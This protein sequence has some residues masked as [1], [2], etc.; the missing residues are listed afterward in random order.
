M[1]KI[2][3]FVLFCA[4]VLKP[5][6][7]R[8]QGFIKTQLLPVDVADLSL[9]N[10]A[11]NSQKVI[12]NNLLG[13]SNDMFSTSDFNK[14]ISQEKE[15]VKTNSNTR[16]K[17][18]IYPVKA[19]TT[20][21]NLPT[22]FFRSAVDGGEWNIAGNWQFSPDNGI[23]PWEIA[24][25][26][27]GTNAAAIIIHNGYNI[28]SSGSITADD[29]IIE[30]G[31]AL[32]ING[33]SFTINNGVAIADLQVDGNVTW[34]DGVFITTG[35]GVSFEA[36]ATYTHAINFSGEIPAAIWDAAATCIVTGMTTSSTAPTGLNQLFG[37]F[38]WNCD[39]T[40]SADN[41]LINNNLFGVAGT[42][43]INHTGAAY[44]AIVGAT[45][46]S[47]TNTVNNIEVNSGTLLLNDFNTGGGYS[48]L[49][50]TGDITVADVTTA[51]LDFVGGAGNPAGTD[52][53]ATLNLAGNLTVGA[54]AYFSRSNTAVNTNSILFFNGTVGTQMVN[55]GY[56]L[57][58]SRGRIIYSVQ[59]DA[60]VQL[61][62]YLWMWDA[63]TMYVYGTI[64]TL[65]YSIANTGG[66]VN[67]AFYNFPG[68]TLITSL[69]NGFTAAAGSG[70]VQT[71]TR[72]YSSAADYEFRGSNTGN[73]TTITT[74]L[75]GTVRNLTINYYGVNMTGNITVTG[76]LKL[77][78][79]GQFTLPAFNTLTLAGTLPAPAGTIDAFS[80]GPST[81]VLANAG[82]TIN[83]LL[84]SPT[85]NLY[86]LNNNPPSGI[87]TLQG[88]FIIARTLT[89][90]GGILDNGNN[91][92]TLGT[93]GNEEPLVKI[94]G[95]LHMDLGSSLT[96]GRV[97]SDATIPDGVFTSGPRFASLKLSRGDGRTVTLGNQGMELFTGLD[98]KRGTLNIGNS[99]LNLNGAY[100]DNSGTPGG[101]LAG[102]STSDLTVTGYTGGK[103]TIPLPDFTDINLRTVT[104]GGART[105]AMASSPVNNINLYGTLSIETQGI[106]DN[107]GESQ[108]INAGGSAAIFIDGTFITRDLQGFTGANAAVSGIDPVLNPECT[109]EYGYTGDQDISIRN[110][111]QN[112]R[113]TGGGIKKP[114]T[115]NDIAPIA[116]T[117]I[118]PDVT[119]VNTEGNIFGSAATN[120]TMFNGRFITAGSGIKPNMNGTYNLSGGV[121]EFAGSETTA[122]TIQT[123]KS[124]L[125][126][127]VT[128]NN[129]GKA[130]G[131]I[132]IKN[133]GTFTVKSNGIFTIIEDAITGPVGSQLVVVES[134]ATFKCGNADGFNGGN[135]TS[136]KSDVE[137]INLNAGSILEYARSSGS[138][139]QV[140]TS[141]ITYHHVIMSGFGVKNLATGTF[142][143]SSTGS[144]DIKAPVVFDAED[145]TAIDF[146]NR[147]VQTRST[148]AGTASLGDLTGVTVQNA[149]DAF[150]VERFMPDRRAWRLITTPL[151]KTGTT[152]IS[153]AWQ[154]GQQSTDRLNPVIG[155]NGI[156]T[157]IT[158]GLI[159]A[160]GYDAGS[161]ANA[162]LKYFNAGNW[163]TPSATTIPINTYPGYML[164]VRGDRQMIITN[165]FA[166]PTIT[167][168]I[169]KGRI[170]IG[171]QNPITAAGFQVVGNPYPS[172]I[173]FKKVIKSGGLEDKYY[174]WDPKLGGAFGAGAFVSFLRNGT[175]YDE[176]LVASDG[177]SIGPSGSTLP[178]DGT[179]ESGAA[180]MADFGA[181]GTGTLQ[182]D[183]SVKINTSASAPFGRPLTPVNSNQLSLRINMAAFNSDSSLFLV[184]GVL[185]TFNADYTNE[186]D[187]N[188]A[189]KIKSFAEN[190]GL[191][192]QEQSIAIE[193]RKLLTEN[194]TIFLQLSGLKVRKYRLELEA[195]NLAKQNLAGYLEDTYLTTSTAINMDGFTSND[196]MPQNISA[197]SVP[198]RFRIVFKKSVTYNTINA[199]RLNN[200]IAIDW[201]VTGERDI[202][203]Y[204]I[205]RSK[206]GANFTA[207]ITTLAKADNSDV[208]Y[209]NGVDEG[210]LF[211]G[212][213]YYRIKSTSN[214]GAIGYSNLAKV[215]VMNAGGNMYVY[216]NPVSNGS[217]GLQMNSM[218]AGIYHL[219]LFNSA[220]QMLFS[221]TINYGGGT[222][223]F[224]I[225]YPLQLKG[226]AELEITGV[227]KKKTVLK[228]IVE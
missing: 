79:G 140:V 66:A 167:T 2:Y 201:S 116:G 53:V 136:V 4:L 123:S 75:P 169:P 99:L 119:T 57:N 10:Y 95:T 225:N 16:S 51:R 35:A 130:S 184:D 24:T 63:D 186:V 8:G 22:D 61:K 217:M 23:T 108:L 41:F 193:R 88:D 15:I 139:N 200:A 101:Y 221:K 102:T 195:K 198:Y 94:N 105:L 9:T 46:A 60:V 191:L 59:A 224:S 25:L 72:V 212:I 100:L 122:Q 65:G 86:Y 76:A 219:R 73:F 135:N 182:F 58:T 33:G 19:A 226:N 117:V 38:T 197:G 177:S 131:D 34:R 28:I 228:V 29:I 49:N 77:L 215:T 188:D 183:E 81:I 143:L 70:A 181:T 83:N 138:G 133:S 89:L 111:Y 98:L 185:A 204:E 7:S 148:I 114:A 56:G 196:F 159:A 71:N 206:D 121:V 142:A 69:F 202:K 118:I 47:F 85:G 90:S 106:Y 156:G 62:N 137:T 214:H 52:Y 55:I 176:T 17:E 220:G 173:D 68:S 93:G 189:I 26:V 147:P 67:T 40:T 164:F 165:Q 80:A 115:A 141:G 39:Q 152:T 210:H 144:L 84:F 1:R 155:S 14:E 172:A 13:I 112:I 30:S 179:I 36:T 120:F 180:F 203:Q 50:V 190:I 6:M 12:A 211:A 43:A 216:P 124:Y 91:S 209:Y 187:A 227:D 74:P 20:S 149:S 213:Y 208:N 171:T 126:I 64:N 97:D 158:N 163:V 42:L 223:S 168:L 162:S 87:N 44:L 125:N 194:D 82:F 103:V 45:T 104:V 150:S 11:F 145:G 174:L 154:N 199:Y 207:I 178:N 129:V 134:D 96:F 192:H 27:P 128:G 5:Q 151:L 110:D 21:S 107:G 54:N 170:N 132:T 92:L 205:E 48:N 175:T 160:N 218:P 78:A 222:A 109:I 31:S 153:A 37:N 3:L 157:S 146:N 32:T 127:E 161:T 166:T 18:K 113:F